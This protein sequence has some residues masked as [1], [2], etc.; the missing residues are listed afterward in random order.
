MVLARRERQHVPAVD[1]D[2]EARLLAV[3]EFLDDDA[4]CR[5]RPMLVVDQHRVDRRVRLGERRRDDDA[6]AGGEPVGLDDDRRAAARRRTHA[7][8][9]RR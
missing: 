3:E 5:Q 7:R 8:P 2:D 1:H 4:R 6:F 9:R